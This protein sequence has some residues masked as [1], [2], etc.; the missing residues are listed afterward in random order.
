VMLADCRLSCGHYSSRLF[1]M[2]MGCKF[3]RRKTQGLYSGAYAPIGTGKRR[4]RPLRSA[5]ISVGVLYFLTT[6]AIG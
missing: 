4:S 3:K 2:R 6:G 1:S 5:N